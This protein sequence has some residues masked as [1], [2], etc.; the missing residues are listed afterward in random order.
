LSQRRQQS[1]ADVGPRDQ[2][3]KGSLSTAL[4][5]LDLELAA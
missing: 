3:N 2:N 4:A 1:D 5:S